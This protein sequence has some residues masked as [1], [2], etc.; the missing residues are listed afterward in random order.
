VHVIELAPRKKGGT[1]KFR[2]FLDALYAKGVAR[3]FQGELEQWS[4]EPLTPTHEIAGHI[5]TAFHTRH[6][7]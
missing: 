7:L 3:P 1:T 2:R 6:T 5:V 4:Y